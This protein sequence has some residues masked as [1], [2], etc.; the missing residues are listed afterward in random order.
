MARRYDE[1][2]AQFSKT[3]DFDP[4]FAWAHLQLAW[5]Y[6]GKSDYEPAITNAKKA[7]ELLPDPIVLLG[8]L[9]EAY[10]AA[11]YQDEAHRILDQLQE[12]S[13][14]QYVTPYVLA[15]IY[16]ALGQKE[17]SLQ[18]LETSYQTRAAWTALVKID[19]QLD[20]L[21]SDARFQGLMRRMKFPE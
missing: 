17:D 7:T 18:W 19:P 13:K 8:M 4:A 1:A 10:A 9:G 11:G 15:R 16:A 3:L 14:Q 5:A 20:G 6:M 21:R 12:R 2:I